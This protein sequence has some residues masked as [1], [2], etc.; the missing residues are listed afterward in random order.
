MTLVVEDDTNVVEWFADKLHQKTSHEKTMALS[1][2]YSRDMKPEIIQD[3]QK[4]LLE[5]INGLSDTQRAQL[6]RNNHLK[7]TVPHRGICEF[8]P[9]EYSSLCERIKNL[10]GG[11]RVWA[12]SNDVF[13]I[14][15][16]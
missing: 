4:D 1:E 12:G 15:Y 2:E 13:K 7:T 16:R 10:T 3:I 5:F 8:I 14:A 6:V 11:Y 9:E